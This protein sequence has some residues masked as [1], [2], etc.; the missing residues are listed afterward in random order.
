MNVHIDAKEYLINAPSINLFLMKHKTPNKCFVY[1]RNN[2]MALNVSYV[3]KKHG[4]QWDVNVTAHY[5]NKD[6]I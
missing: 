5:V 1:L 6:T 4:A 3:E 2:V